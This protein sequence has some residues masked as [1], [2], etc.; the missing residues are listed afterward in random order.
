MG[1]KMIPVEALMRLQSF[2]SPWVA[3]IDIPQS[4]CCGLFVSFSDKSV[5]TVQYQCVTICFN[6]I[7][8]IWKW[9]VVN[10]TC[11][12]CLFVVQ[13][14]VCHPPRSKASCSDG[15]FIAQIGPLSFQAAIEHKP[16]QVRWGGLHAPVVTEWWPACLHKQ[17]PRVH[18]GDN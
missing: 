1:N 9:H 17:F 4:R 16:R 15:F 2:Y 3:G 12:G 5:K 13:N 7:V 8:Q 11:K 18:H 6:I 10:C 14:N